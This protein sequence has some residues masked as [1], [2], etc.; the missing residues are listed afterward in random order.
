MSF[1]QKIINETF[2]HT[3]LVTRFYDQKLTLLKARDKSFLESKY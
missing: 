2:N 3:H 1:K